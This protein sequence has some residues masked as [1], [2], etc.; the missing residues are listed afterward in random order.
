MHITIHIYILYIQHL[1]VYICINTYVSSV[2]VYI[3][4]I[5]YIIY[6]YI[7]LWESPSFTNDIYGLLRWGIRLS[8]LHSASEKPRN[9]AAAKLGL[10][11][12]AG[13]SAA[14]CPHLKQT[15]WKVTSP[16][17][18][19]PQIAGLMKAPLKSRGWKTRLSYWGPVTFQGRTV[20][21]REGI[22]KRNSHSCP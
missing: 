21:L 13:T 15:I 16:I 19:T 11:R 6:I 12:P 8:F 4:Y 7:H 1:C 20:E 3:V 2:Y 9:V 18:P 17:S 14:G 10:I 5:S 22:E